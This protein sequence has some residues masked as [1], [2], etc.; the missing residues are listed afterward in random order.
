ML[1]PR[2]TAVTSAIRAGKDCEMR[3]KI[4]GFWLA[5]LGLVSAA[6]AQDINYPTRGIRM[7]VPFPPGGSVDVTARLVSVQLQERLGQPVTIENRPGAVGTIGANLVAKSAPDGHTLV[8]TIGAHTIVP[9]L[10][11]SIPFDASKDFAA[12]TLLASAPNMLVVKPEFPAR[13][14]KDLVQLARDNPGKFSYS[15]AGNGSTTHIMMAML[16]QAAGLA[17]LHVP[18]Q[19]GAPS[20]Q[21]VLGGQ[22]DLNAAVSTTAL[23][24]VK[25]GRLRA[26]AIVGDKR[27]PLFPDVPTYAEAGYPGI[28]GDSWIGLFAPAGTPRPILMKLHGEI[29]RIMALPDVR[30][31][32]TAQALD[33]VLAGPDEFDR[34][35]KE[36]LRDFAALAKA[37]GLKM[38]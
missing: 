37:V 36:E 2:R 23:P 5:L 7:V 4:V 11:A 1:P 19:G 16:S 20:L 38:E 22:T 24:M 13:T 34:I 3:V 15:T 31:K 30:Q 12:V 35:V 10:M 17:M 6:I 26:L 14:L 8:M 21:A 27:S 33:P 18:F 28:R 29:Q 9:A 32:I 25:A